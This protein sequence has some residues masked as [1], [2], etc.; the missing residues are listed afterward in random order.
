MRR[1]V[2]IAKEGK[3]PWGIKY[4]ANLPI[5]NHVSFMTQDT[6]TAQPDGEHDKAL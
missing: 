5:A 4:M 1:L 6:A 3:P 2:W